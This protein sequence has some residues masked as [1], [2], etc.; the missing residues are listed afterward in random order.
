MIKL[1]CGKS[2]TFRFRWITGDVSLDLGLTQKWKRNIID[3][4]T[5]GILFLC[6]KNNVSFLEGE[7]KF[8]GPK[9]LAVTTANGDQ[10]VEFKHCIIATGSVPIEIPGFQ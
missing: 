2:C 3:Q 10:E 9:T 6:K 7:T 4:L 5:K 8:T 1:S